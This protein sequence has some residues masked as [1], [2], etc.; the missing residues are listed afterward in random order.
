MKRG[1]ADTDTRGRHVKM[2]ADIRAI[3]LQARNPQKP[4]QRPGAEGASPANTLSLTCSL[5]KGEKTLLTAPSVALGYGSHRVHPGHG[6]G[7][8]QSWVSVA[9]R[10][11][12]ETITIGKGRER[13]GISVSFSYATLQPRWLNLFLFFKVEP[14]TRAWGET[15]GGFVQTQTTGVS[16]SAGLG[17]GGGT[18]CLVP[19]SCCWAGVGSGFL[20]PLLYGV[21]Q[22]H[23]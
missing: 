11:K 15:P 9:R 23:A 14:P 10:D 2:E 5:Q 13:A 18:L 7:S 3:L 19:G 17:R 22:V 4:G 8:G 1:H 6:G 20:E 16:D 21:E 12:K